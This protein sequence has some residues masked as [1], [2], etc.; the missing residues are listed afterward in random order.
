MSYRSENPKALRVQDNTE[1]EKRR[2]QCGE[3][4]PVLFWSLIK[5]CIVV[6]HSFLHHKAAAL[7]FYTLCITDAYPLAPML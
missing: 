6:A 2:V 7:R 5:I 1:D 4:K 3:T